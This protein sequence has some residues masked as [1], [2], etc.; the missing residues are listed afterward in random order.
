MHDSLAQCY[1]VSLF[2]VKSGFI[3]SQT[4]EQIEKIDLTFFIT[5]NFVQFSFFMQSHIIQL[6]FFI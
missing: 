2:P 5:G 4:A 3:Q 1:Q 6:I